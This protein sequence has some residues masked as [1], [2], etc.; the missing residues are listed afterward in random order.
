MQKARVGFFSLINFQKARR[1]K[2]NTKMRTFNSDIK[3][4]LI[5]QLRNNG[6][7]ASTI[8][9]VVLLVLCTGTGN[10]FSVRFFDK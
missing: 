2:L 3:S 8:L 9:D 7:D 5:I 6:K 10:Q 1:V 4:V